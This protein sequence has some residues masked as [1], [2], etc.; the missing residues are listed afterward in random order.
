[1]ATQISQPEF[2][3]RLRRLRL[4][5]GLSQRDL[6]VGAVN[7][8]YISLLESGARVPTL[9]VVLHLSRVLEVPLHTLAG[10]LALS[11]KTA[12]EDGADLVQALLIGSAIVNGDLERAEERLRSCYRASASATRM[13]YRGLALDRVLELRGDRAARYQLLRELLPVAERIGVPEALVRVR[14]DLAAA[15]RDAGDL[16]EAFT[17]IELAERQIGQTAFLDDSEHVRLLCIRISVLSDAGGGVEVIRLTDTMLAVAAKI[18]SPAILGRAHW[19]AS[20]ALA[21]VGEIARSLEHLRTAR[22]MLANP[23]TSLRDWA[24]FSRAAVSALMD[25]EA[26]PAEIT[27][28]MQ[29]ARAAGAAS[30]AQVDAAAWT[31]LEVRY[32][33]A[34]GDPELALRLAATVDEERLTGIERVRFALAVGR[35][36]HRLGRS[37]EARATLRRAAQLAESAAAHRLSARIWREIDEDLPP[38]A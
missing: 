5:R 34:T 21:R 8:S 18:N 23:T 33:L 16:T 10:T 24:R 25:A 9:D 22:E 11:G 32:A 4:E 1:M 27:S 30:D 13:L 35:A 29:I 3:Q 37:A 28:Q 6:A 20:L 31:S 36:Q 26:D 12:D 2:G 38:G 17:Q 19:T 14:I 15:A 7:Q